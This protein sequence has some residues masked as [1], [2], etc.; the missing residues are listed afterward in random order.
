MSHYL[1]DLLLSSSL[2]EHNAYDS[3]RKP[4]SAINENGINALETPSAA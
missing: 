4:A 3:Y 2:A 1:P